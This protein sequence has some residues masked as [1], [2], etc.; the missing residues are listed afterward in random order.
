MDTLATFTRQNLGPIF[1]IALIFALAG[2]GNPTPV[3]GTAPPTVAPV[4]DDMPVCTASS[5]NGATG[6]TPASNTVSPPKY[7]LPAG[8]PDRDRLYLALLADDSDGLTTL[9]A[10]GAD[11]NSKRGRKYSVDADG[12]VTFAAD[13]DDAAQVEPVSLLHWAA[14][15][16]V[17]GQTISVLIA[18]G[19]DVKAKDSRGSTPLMEAA[20]NAHLAAAGLQALIDAGASVLDRDQNKMDAMMNAA[21]IDNNDHATVCL[22]SQKLGILTHAGADLNENVTY[23]PIQMAIS[24]RNLGM[25]KLIRGLGGKIKQVAAIDGSTTLHMMAHAKDD[26]IGTAR[27]IL[28]RGVDRRTEDSAHKTALDIFR[29]NL[30]DGSC[31]RTDPA[32]PTSNLCA[33]GV[34]AIINAIEHRHRK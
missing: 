12:L 13:A 1:P 15:V 7:H 25:A 30:K 31:Y 24:H 33:P 4:A 21:S 8:A 22:M 29:Q 17:S 34:Q 2:C 6:A 23:T 27:W 26:Q 9:L 19:A 14:S 5:T 18:H 10:A 16:S 28:S 11:A 32:H 3:A 20:K